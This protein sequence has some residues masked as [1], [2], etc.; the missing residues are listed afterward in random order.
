MIAMS[1]KKILL[2]C[3]FFIFCLDCGAARPKKASRNMENVRKEKK[4]TEEQIRAAS[5]QLEENKRKTARSLN[6]LN[7][8][9]AEV[10]EHK[11]AISTLN[12]QILS[13]DN[14]MASLSDSI[15]EL[16]GKLET[17]RKSYASSVKRIKESR[18]GITSKLAF[19]FASESFMQAYR[20]MR[21]LQEFSAW[22]KKKSDEIQVVKA[23]LEDKKT[24]LGKLQKA[25]AES[26]IKLK[27]EHDALS[28]KQ[29]E[30]SRLV[31]QLK[32]EGSAINEVLKE[33]EAQARAL[34]RELDRLIAE[35]QKRQEE[36]RRKAEER[37]LAEE[38][39][40]AEERRIAEEKRL[41]E[42]KLA[43]EK[44]VQAKQ[45]PLVASSK[46]SE[47]KAKDVKPDKTKKNEPKKAELIAYATPAASKA[48][49]AVAVSADNA[50]KL[51]NISGS[52]ESNK[53]RLPFPVAGKYKIVRAYGRQ[54]HPDLPHVTTENS[55]IDIEVSPGSTARA[56]FNG[57][58]SAIFRQPGFNTI[59]MIRHGNYLTVYANLGDILVK[60]GEEVK[61]GQTI[62]RVYADPDD[63]NRSILH[64][65][66]RK[67]REKLNPTAWVK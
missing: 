40:I 3:A 15:S 17:M 34:D 44:E 7:T 5:L 57:K 60:N 1:I 38:K 55:G 10:A 2:L 45:N 26:L 4:M 65:E 46:K 59:V 33:K 58:V 27:K 63:G 39:R 22:R 36:E 43:K 62:G 56:I 41:A 16:D 61:A 42:E 64:F 14:E 20:R 66:L 25:K 31:A 48:K 11:E 23:D 9:N 18:T 32:S 50:A 51:I 8:L 49:P 24:Q 47:K 6:A 13:L 35:E 30:T 12:G 28:V 52:F 19:I 53:G 37:R 21:Y 29:N 67:E 54:Q